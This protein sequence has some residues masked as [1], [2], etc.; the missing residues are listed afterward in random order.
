[1]E[2]T[3]SS[4]SGR[5]KPCLSNDGITMFEPIKP[6]AITEMNQFHAAPIQISAP[7]QKKSFLFGAKI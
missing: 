4:F 7:A 3:E 2:I 6:D 5:L 1:M